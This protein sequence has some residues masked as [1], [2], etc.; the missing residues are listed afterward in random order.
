MNVPKNNNK[1]IDINSNINFY[2]LSF[3]IF[4]FSLN[5][6]SAP[7][8]SDKLTVNLSWHRQAKRLVI[9][10]KDEALI[11]RIQPRSGLP[12][13]H[14]ESAAAWVGIDFPYNKAI[15]MILLSRKYYKHLR[16]IALSDYVSSYTDRYDN[17]LFIGGSTR[18][19]LKLNL[20]AW[21]E[22]DFKYVKKI[23]SNKK[24]HAF[25]RARY[26]KDTSKRVKKSN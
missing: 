10:A 22:K 21:T 24:F 15:R 7:S 3:I 16:Y 1:N 20:K 9:L 19:A 4:I 26:S 8:H 12:Y 6:F 11:A 13:S 5:C 14:N 17:D 25:I 2:I 23:K 18:K